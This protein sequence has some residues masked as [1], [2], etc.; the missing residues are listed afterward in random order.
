[1]VENGTKLTTTNKLCDI[2]F[3]F[4][5][6]FSLLIYLCY[7]DINAIIAVLDFVVLTYTDKLIPVTVY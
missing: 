3:D 1:M 4:K 5:M 2:V 7:S 6:R